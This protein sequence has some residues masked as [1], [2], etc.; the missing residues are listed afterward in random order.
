MHQLPASLPIMLHFSAALHCLP[1]SGR[2]LWYQMGKHKCFRQVRD[3]LRRTAQYQILTGVIKGH[4]FLDYTAALFHLLVQLRLA[5]PQLLLAAGHH[6]PEVTGFWLVWG[7]GLKLQTAVT[8]KVI[9]SQCK[10][11]LTDLI[12]SQKAKKIKNKNKNATTGSLKKR[13]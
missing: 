12:L 7:S 8:D 3:L 9:Q 4:F 1:S 13:K 6:G 10:P 5:A 2:L 11:L